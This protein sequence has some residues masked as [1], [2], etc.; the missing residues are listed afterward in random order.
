MAAWAVGVNHCAGASKEERPQPAGRLR[1]FW[2][3]RR[4]EEWGWGEAVER[5]Q[6]P[7]RPEKGSAIRAVL[8]RSR[9]ITVRIE[10]Q[11]V[12]PVF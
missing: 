5:A 3:D 11:R 10:N 2:F 8:N 9:E 12:P 4:G 6:E 7:F 1:A